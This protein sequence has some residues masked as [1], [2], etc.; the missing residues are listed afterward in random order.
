MRNSDDR[1][2][3]RWQN[4]VIL[5]YGYYNINLL[6]RCL[7][8]NLP[9]R[10]KHVAHDGQAR[11]PSWASTVPN[12]NPNR[13]LDLVC[14]LSLINRKIIQPQSPESM[15]IVGELAQENRGKINI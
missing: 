6:G 1:N 5:E 15:L 3:M 12:F 8:A 11:C 9:N 13:S 14:I 10:G 7:T 4:L 2:R